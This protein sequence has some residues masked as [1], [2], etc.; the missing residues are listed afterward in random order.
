[1]K[2][3]PAL[4]I[5]INGL[6]SELKR[7]QPDQE[8][9]K[10]LAGLQLSGAQ[11]ISW[12]D[13]WHDQAALYF[14][15]DI[16]AE[17]NYNVDITDENEAQTGA[18]DKAFKAWAKVKTEEAKVVFKDLME[19]CDKSLEDPGCLL[20]NETVKEDL[21]SASIPWSK[22]RQYRALDKIM[23]YKIYGEKDMD[24]SSLNEEDFEV[25]QTAI[26]N[27]IRTYSTTKV[28]SQDGA[29]AM[30]LDPDI[31]EIL[32]EQSQIATPAAFEIQKYYWA[33]WH[34]KVGRACKKDF[35]EF[36][37]VSNKAAVNNGYKDTGDSWKGWYEDDQFEEL[38]DR[39]WG[40][41]K[42]LYSKLHAYARKVLSSKDHYGSDLVN[43]EKKAPLPAN[44]LGNMWGQDWAGLYDLLVPFKDA[45]VRPDAT[46][47]LQSLEF[48]DMYAYSDD[49]YQ[50][51]GHLPMTRRFWANSV[52]E[53][54]KSGDMVCHASAWDFMAGPGRSGD[55]PDGDYRIKQCTVK[56]QSNFVTIH[57]EMG[58]IQYFQQYAH[59]PIIFRSGA[60]PGFHEA[61]GDTMA[62][63]VGTPKHLNKVGLLPYWDESMESEKSDLNFLMQM[64][65]DKVT[66]LPF[67]YLMDK[68]RW[69]VFRKDVQK[70]EYQDLWDR[71]RLE[72][73]GLVSPVERSAE[74]FDPAAK[75]HLSNNVPYIRYFVSFVIQ[76]QFYEKMCKVAGQYDP[77]DPNKPLYKCDFYEDKNAGELLGVMLQ[78]GNS[79]RWQDILKEFLCAKESQG[80][81][82]VLSAKSLLNY[83]APLNAWL[84]EQLDEA[85]IGW[86][87]AS[88]WTPAGFENFPQEAQPSATTNPSTTTKK[89]DGNTENPGTD[90]PNETTTDSFKM[91]TAS[92][93]LMIASLFL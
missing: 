13:G 71:L 70:D 85:E 20:E 65:L 62:L 35:E 84:D 57:H 88:V 14:T 63:S 11:V 89:P 28:W 19:A 54:S 80:C 90:A 25:Y 49:F 83:F 81:E 41:L 26:Q 46:P 10:V 27:M 2:L 17:W 39:I 29:K 1:M 21:E 43:H 61:I 33:N 6:R 47:A 4:L 53:K 77:N 58:H 92:L 45:G 5:G 76:F 56:T 37:E 68:Y 22:E 66:F 15:N 64:A 93:G 23:T 34:K 8:Y 82:G 16:K 12:L 38:A 3:L 87:E 67:G 86:D 42:P 7:D 18:A 73:Q 72:I 59:Q 30:E 91:L 78:K 69:M 75:F 60:N 32:Y 36:V 24:S 51:L 48:V 52:F 55:G 44:I 79:E 50:S 31:D 40:E 9:W 74:D